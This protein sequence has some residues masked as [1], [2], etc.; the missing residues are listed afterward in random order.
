MRRVAA[1]VLL[2]G[3]GRTALVRFVNVVDSGVVD[4]RADDAGSRDAGAVDAGTVDAGIPTSCRS[5]TGPTMNM[6]CSARVRVL[7]LV[8]TMPTCF[9][10]TPFQVGSVGEL[11]WDCGGPT[12]GADLAFDAGRFVGSF[13]Q[14]LVDVCFGSTFDWSDGCTWTSAQTIRGAPVAGTRLSMTYGEAPLPGQQGCVV[15]CA[16]RGEL[17]VLP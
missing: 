1:A 3:C 2:L 8:P 7:S 12:G 10:D 15:P 13:S 16:A 17:E 4:V 14:G 6:P 9:V 5:A 11:R